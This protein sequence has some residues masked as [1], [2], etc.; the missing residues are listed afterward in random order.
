MEKDKQEP[1]Y[2]VGTINDF[3]MIFWLD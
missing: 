2:K 1:R 3:V